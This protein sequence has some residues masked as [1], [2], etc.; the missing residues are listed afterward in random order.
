MQ[1]WARYQ[2][3]CY[4]FSLCLYSMNS[5]VYT[6]TK[7]CFI[8]GAWHESVT[9]GFNSS[10]TG[11][12]HTNLASDGIISNNVNKQ[13]FLITQNRKYMLK[14]FSAVSS[15]SLSRT[16]PTVSFLHNDYSWEALKAYLRMRRWIRHWMSVK[17]ILVYHQMWILYFNCSC[18][19]LVY[20]K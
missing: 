8:E 20:Y 15:W 2:F 1:V 19:I 7:N 5:C 14:I 13:V 4:L 16:A 12:S 6:K 3:S 9:S 11:F 17:S 18:N 10:L